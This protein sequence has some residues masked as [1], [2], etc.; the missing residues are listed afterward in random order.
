MI[1]E[2]LTVHEKVLKIREMQIKTMII[3]LTYQNGYYQKDNKW[4]GCEKEHLCT[5][6]GKV[7]WCSHYKHLYRGFLQSET[8]LSYDPENSHLGK[9]MKESKHCPKRYLHPHV[10]CSITYNSQDMTTTKVWQQA[11]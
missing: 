4:W 10:H 3:H 5:V 9:H 1:Y 11:Y 2:W 7:N 6:C 8:E